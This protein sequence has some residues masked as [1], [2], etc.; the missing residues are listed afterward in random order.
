MERIE[1][2]TMKTLL[3]LTLVTFAQSI[4]YCNFTLSTKNL[5]LELEQ[6]HSVDLEVT[7]LNET[8]EYNTILEFLIQN[9]DIV[10]VEPP[11][12]LVDPVNSTHQFFIE[13][14]SA[15]HTEVVISSADDTVKFKPLYLIVNVFKRHYLDILS[16]I[17]GWIYILSW[18]ASYYP[19]IFLN[20]KRKSV[21]GLNFD[22]V[23]LNI[24]GYCMYGIFILNVFFV[25]DIQDEYFRRHPR[26]LIPV[27]IN[28][29]VY[30][31][32]GIS[33]LI[34]TVIQCFVYEKGNQIVTMFGRVTLTL[35]FT[36]SLIIVILAG[37]NVIEWLDFLYY[38]S[39]NKVII[40]ALK[41]IP[42]AYMNYK[43]KSTQGWS[44]GLV[45]LQLSGG[46][47]S[48]LQMI[49]DSYNYNDWASIFGN[50]TKFLAGMLNILFPTYF[51][52][53]HYVLY[54]PTPIINKV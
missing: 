5:L 37:L 47:F 17:F 2:F 28:D 49:L 20:Y 18:G 11:I 54:R 27:K 42:Q 34:V 52:I 40:T 24:V 7:C 16:K 48:V 44:I 3:L 39:Y 35:I 13:A 15:G 4:S 8:D 50:P 45:I 6:E 29:V 22:F 51:V 46:I 19:Q 1:D 25:G 14:A 53:Q 31:I 30:N 36:F 38:C 10:N 23:A 26:G 21:I 41:Y 12:L 9:K 43:R 32:H 33:A